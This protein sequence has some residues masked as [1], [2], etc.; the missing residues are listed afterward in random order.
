MIVIGS[1]FDEFANKY[2]SVKKKQVCLALRYISHAN[3]CDLVFSSVKEKLP[4]ALFKAMLGRYLG[5]SA[6]APKVERDHNQ[7]LNIYAG[8]DV[9]AQIGEPEGSG[10]RRNVAFE[11]LWQELVEAQIPK[12]AAQGGAKDPAQVLGDMRRYAEDK[13]DNMRQQKDE[14]LEQYKKEIERAKRFESQK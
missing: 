10:N 5:E 7:P 8:S 11:K 2:E 9:F 14:E 6:A 13:V 12:T 4:T 1:K 3:G